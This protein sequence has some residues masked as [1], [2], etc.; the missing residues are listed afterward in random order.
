LGPYKIVDG[1][2]RHELVITRDHNKNITALSNG[3]LHNLFKIFRNRFKFFEE[4]ACSNYASLFQS[5]GPTAGGSLYHPHYQLLSLPIVPPDI[6]RSLEG[7]LRYYRENGECVHCGIIKFEMKN[8][9]RVVYENDCTVV[10]APFASR[11]PYEL[12]IFPK[13]H[14]SRFEYSPDNVLLCTADALVKVLTAI[15]EK[16]GDPDYNFFLHTSPFHGKQ[17]Y[18]HYHWHMEVIPKLSLFGGFEWST[19][20]DINSVDPD[21][22]AELL[23]SAIK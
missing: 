15:K 13:Q 7:S 9:S 6:R 19:G 12:R 23:R 17:E 20:I 3:E 11:A 10:I 1:V 2:G 4:D 16:L 14:Q 8:S 21:E 22:A 18:S 5:Y